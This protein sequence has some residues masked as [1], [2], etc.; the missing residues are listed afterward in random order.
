MS[1]YDSELVRG[2][3][4]QAG[5]PQRRLENRAQPKA[6]NDAD[7]MNEGDKMGAFLRNIEKNITTFTQNINELL[8]NH[9][10]RLKLVESTGSSLERLLFNNLEK[11]ETYQ[12]N[13]GNCPICDH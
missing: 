2:I 13:S 8:K 11:Y 5:A 4:N 9:N 10:I 6:M 7:E 12:C 3:L 1:R